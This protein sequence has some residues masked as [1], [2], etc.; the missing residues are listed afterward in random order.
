VSVGEKAVVAN[1]HEAIRE[2]MEKKPAKKLARVESHG[3]PSIVVSV[4]LV[5]ESDLSVVE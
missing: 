5:S 1:P 3:S 2:H 4:V